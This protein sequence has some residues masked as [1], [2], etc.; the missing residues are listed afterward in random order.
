MQSVPRPI[1]PRCRPMGR[2]ALCAALALGAATPAA[3]QPRVP[4]Y[5]ATTVDQEDPVGRSLVYALKE[6]LRS[7]RG[8]RLVEDEAAWPYLSMRVVTLS[9]SAGGTAMAV[10]FVYDSIEMP[11][12]GAYITTSIQTCGRDRVTSCSTSLMGSL[13]AASDQLRRGNQGLWQTLR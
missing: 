10:A 6:S 11:M 5:L 2:F 12:G 1:V 3:A 8:F 13:D 9:T 4:V 7:S